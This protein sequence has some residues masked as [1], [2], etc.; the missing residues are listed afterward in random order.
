MRKEKEKVTGKGKEDFRFDP[1]DP[2]RDQRSS[3]FGSS[4][5]SSTDRYSDPF[6]NPTGH[7]FLSS[8]KT[9][10]GAASTSGYSSRSSISSDKSVPLDFSTKSATSGKKADM[11]LNPFAAVVRSDKGVGASTISAE[12]LSSAMK[13]VTIGVQCDLFGTDK[14]TTSVST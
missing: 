6:A 10:S 3:A 4:S 8:T 12:K 1:F 14:Q 11:R 13:Q 7:G 2:L 5:V 9:S